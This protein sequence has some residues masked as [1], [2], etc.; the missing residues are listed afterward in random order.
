MRDVL[1]LN[2]VE[3]QLD[4]YTVISFDSLPEY[5][6]VDYDLNNEKDFA[7]YILDV[8]ADARKS[9]EYTRFMNFL[10]NNLDMNRCSFFENVVGGN[11]SKVKIE[12]HHDPFTIEDIIR[13]VYRKRVEYCELLDVEQVS[14][15]VM[16]LHYNILVGLIP[17]S[18]TV[19]ELIG[20]NYLFVPTTHVMGNYKE[21][22]DRY[23]PFIDGETLAMLKRIEEATEVYDYSRA[24]NI[25]KKH[26]VYINVGDTQLPTYDT[27]IQM[28]RD[29][30]AELNAKKAIPV[31]PYSNGLRKPF[32]KVDE[33]DSKI[34]LL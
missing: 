32:I 15:E 4:E 13:I 23:E 12:I 1:K 22:V 2:P 29:R 8:K 27:I 14:K 31:N 17:A 25:L 11:R 26:Y 30:L 10:K 7:H 3:Y 21:F 9:I 20:N 33:E 18:T 5:D 6:R 28:M 24:Q 16:F 34:E 19:H